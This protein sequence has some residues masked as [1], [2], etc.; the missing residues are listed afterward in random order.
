MNFPTIEIQEG[1][2][3]N[4]R[5]SLVT[6][7]ERM[8]ARNTEGIGGGERRGVVFAIGREIS[9]TGKCGL[10]HIANTCAAAVFGQLLF[11]SDKRRSEEHTSELQ[12]L[13]RNSYAVFCFKK[14]TK[15]KNIKNSKH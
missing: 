13:M 1:F 3:R 8:I 9:R 6:V 5:R 4:Q 10:K 12:S 11:M 7:N 2:R 14:K 15:N